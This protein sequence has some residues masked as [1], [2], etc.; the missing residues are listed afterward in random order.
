MVDEVAGIVGAGVSAFEEDD[1]L[2]LLEKALPA[3]IKLMETLLESSPDNQTLLVLLARLYG[4]YAFVFFDG[5]LEKAELT[6]EAPSGASD[7]QNA[8]ILRD[9][10]NRYYQKGMAYALRALEARHGPNRDDLKK[11][12]TRDL[13]FKQLTKDDVPALFWYGFNLGF[14][15]NLNRQSVKAMSQAS[16]LE[17]SMQRVLELDP[18]Y[19]HGSAHL[20]LFAYYA[21]RPPMLGGNLEKALA[22]YQQLKK[23]AGDDF[24]M[25]DVFYARYY[26]PK[27]QDRKGYKSVLTRVQEPVASR[28]AYRLYNKVAVE[29]AKTYL[30]ATDQFFE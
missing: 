29:R 13:F 23:I 4:S 21:S 16:L 26:L 2:D 25:S 14:Y 20:F 18:G 27:T 11:I 17:K 19:Y 6:G 7:E 24:L 8:E 12:A 22:H 5:K 9:S 30:E 3:N 1:D 10:V 28:T 15:V